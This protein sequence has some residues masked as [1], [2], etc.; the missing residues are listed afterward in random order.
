MPSESGPS[1]R[2]LV[3]AM[4]ELSDF[5]VGGWRAHPTNNN[6]QTGGSVVLCLNGVDKLI[7]LER[8]FIRARRFQALVEWY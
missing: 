3:P 4:L 6:H 1:Y 7:G 5:C 8:F 2:G